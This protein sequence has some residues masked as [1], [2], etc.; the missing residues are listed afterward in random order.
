ML[1]LYTKACGGEKTACHFRKE[2]IQGILRDILFF[3]WRMFYMDQYNGYGYYGGPEDPYYQKGQYNNRR[4]SMGG[5]VA[6]AIVSFIAGCLV[7]SLLFGNSNYYKDYNGNE[8]I[9]AT[10]A[11]PLPTVT[12]DPAVPAL[13]PVPTGRIMPQFDGASPSI[14]NNSNPIP[15][16]VEQVKTGIVSV[17][18]YMYSSE[19]DA[20]VPAGS[21]T[22]FFISSEGYIATNAHI[23]DGATS[24]GV[25]L[26]DG[27]ELEAE[28]VG[29]DKVY[30]VAVLKVDY[31]SVTPLKLGDSDA[32]RVGEFVVAIGDPT[33]RELAS[34]PT[35][36]I[37]S[38][39]ARDVNID[40]QSNI[41][42]QTDAAVNPGNSG[43]PLL[44]MKGEVVGVVSAK[45]ITA[46]YDEYGN[47]ISAE[48]LGFALPI[49]GA[50]EVIQTLITDGHVARPGLG[51][52]VVAVETY[53]ANKYDIPLGMLVSSV[54]VNSSADQA[55]VKPGDIIVKFDGLAV[56][57]QAAFVTSISGKSVGDKVVFELWRKGKT[58]EVTVTIGDR[59]TFGSEYVDD[60][61]IED[62]SYFEK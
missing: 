1:S 15:D 47:A 18:N 28:L 32:V 3:K 23:I 33:G 29:V 62:F 13:T 37:I 22:G 48:G 44:N 31:A 21:G 9:P 55:G 38:A 6:T 14:G 54:F 43:G 7:M 57:D 19:E 11:T 52:S 42:L 30:D 39:T 51:I 12:P 17:I 10:S 5:Y 34:T 61:V 50:I 16:I 49:N 2:L 4:R 41:Y 60:M 58:L 24:I 45:T 46:S 40:G 35:F 59:N 8:P 56:T 26:N 20:D 27:T 53:E 25:A 36:G